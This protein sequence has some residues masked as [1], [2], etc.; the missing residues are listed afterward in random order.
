MQLGM[1]MQKTAKK[2]PNITSYVINIEGSGIMKL[3]I[4]NKSIDH[5]MFNETNLGSSRK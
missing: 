5:I 1:S 2:L 3:Y 4:F